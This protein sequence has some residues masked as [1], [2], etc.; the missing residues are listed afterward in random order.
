MSDL[1]KLDGHKSSNHPTMEGHKMK[2][3]MEAKG[4]RPHHNA[5]RSMDSYT[6]KGL[7]AGD[8]LSIT[9]AK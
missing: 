7:N 8:A 2:N 9:K 6:S 3:H 5:K 4:N 1:N